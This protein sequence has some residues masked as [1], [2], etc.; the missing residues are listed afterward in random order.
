MIG[1]AVAI[2]I[3]VVTA[4]LQV[5]TFETEVGITSTGVA[6][7]RV[8]GSAGGG[9]VGRVAGRVLRRYLPRE[10]LPPGALAGCPGELS[11]LG[12]LLPPESTPPPP[13]PTLGPP[14]PGPVLPVE[15]PGALAGWP[16]EFSGDTLPRE[17][18]LLLAS[19]PY[20]SS[21]SWSPVSTPP[22]GALAGWP[23]EF[24]GDTLPRELLPPG[25]LAG[26]PGEFSGDTRPREPWSPCRRPMKGLRNI[27]SSNRASKSLSTLEI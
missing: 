21:P 15:P 18:L 17:L 4:S 27:A 9:R 13:S 10:L 2:R 23:G 20:F 26:W 1:N 3:N 8:S 5:G 25:A 12:E 19:E 16:G 11:L 14:A 6:I 22:P 7:A 24:S